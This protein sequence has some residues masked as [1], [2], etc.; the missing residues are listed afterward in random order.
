VIGLTAEELYV[1]AGG[2]P[3]PGLGPLPLDPGD[4]AALRLM[5]NT[6]ERSLRARGLVDAPALLDPLIDP[7]WFA[8]AARDG[9][10]RAWGRRGDRASE[11]AQVAATDY[12]LAAI[13]PDAIRARIA[14]VLELGGDDVTHGDPETPDEER[15]RA[16]LA[17]PAQVVEATRARHGDVV[18]LQWIDPGDGEPVWLLGDGDPVQVSRTGRAA[19]L[20]R[21]S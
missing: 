7:D 4:E 16:L 1:L 11:L 13:E 20:A 9:R 5:R 3:L 14:A 6:A 15:M 2:A 17:P 10:L 19:I 18:A 21:L 8:T 12:T